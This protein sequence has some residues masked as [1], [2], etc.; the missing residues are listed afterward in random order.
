MQG[1]LS[2]SVGF[3]LAFLVASAVLYFNFLTIIAANCDTASF[4]MLRAA[5]WVIFLICF[6]GYLLARDRTHLFRILRMT[7][8][9][10]GTPI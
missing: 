2:T 8:R 10:K 9:L 7:L 1:N 6:D 5:F 3:R 4:R